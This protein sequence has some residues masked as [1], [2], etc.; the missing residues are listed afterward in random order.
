MRFQKGIIIVI[1]TLLLSG[2]WD[3]TQYKDLTIVPFIG[4]EGEEGEITAM[5][6]FPTFQNGK[7]EYSTSQGKGVSTRAARSDANNQTM[8]ALDMAHLEV[9]LM[10]AD[11]A[12]TDFA[13][14]LDMF[15]RTPRNRITSYIALVEGEMAT[16]FNPPGKMKSD[17][18][19]FYPELLRTV[20]L[21]S[22][23]ANFTLQDAMKT[24][25]DPA[26][27]LSLPYL[28]I[29]EETGI[30]KVVGSGLFSKQ[31]YT[32]ITL[33]SSESISAVIMANQMNKYA[34]MTFEWEKKNTQITVNVMRVK[35]KWN[36]GLDNITASYHLDVSIE[37]YAPHNLHEK[38][39]REEVAAFL[40]T[41]FKEH[42][43]AVIKKTQEAESDILGFGR[44]VRA[45]HQDLWNK[46]DWQK[47]YADLP[48]EVEVNVRMKLT[49][50]TE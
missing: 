46:D 2:C 50:I 34:R 8:E 16:Y 48:I 47:T 20:V 39:N 24:M 7:I 19:Y 38:K 22:Y 35:K 43:D 33:S 5:F 45:F 27:D 18:S 14:S 30:P 31:R 41:T 36:I 4:I 32:G 3:E 9:I 21:Y 10:S 6:A 29:N 23:G 40:E 11:L 17:V 44:K 42:F 26:I 25:F 12:K 28:R 37:E 15:F 1:L 49:N 13:P